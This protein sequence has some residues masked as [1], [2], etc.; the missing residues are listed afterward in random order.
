MLPELLQRVSLFRLLHRID[1]D[2]AAQTRQ[3]GCP[4]CKGP[5]HTASYLRKP[6]GG[7]ETVPEEYCRRLS[8]CCGRE[9]CRR[10]VLPP[11]CLFMGRRAYFGCVILIVMA[12]HQHRPNGLGATK[13]MH[14]FSVPKKT[15][16]RWIYYFRDEFPQSTSWQ[17]LRGQVIAHIRDSD[18]PGGLLELFLHRSASAVKALASCLRFLAAGGQAF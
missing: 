8:L 17:R 7:P 9:S 2:L 10:R 6:R 4:F 16:E 3:Q 12:L 18:L 5:L 11:S 14:M 13:L 1:A 15:I